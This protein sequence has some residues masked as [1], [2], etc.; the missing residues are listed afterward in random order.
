MK[1]IFLSL[2]MLGSVS[3]VTKEVV[4]VFQPVSYHDTDSASE[5]GVKGQL[6]QAAVVDR[7]VVLSGAFPED[8][9][10][11]VA[12]PH[13]LPTN[14]PTYEVEEVNLLLICGLALEVTRSENSIEV[15]LD[16]AGLKVPETVELTPRQII[17]MTIEAIRRTLR[18]YYQEGAHDTFECHLTLSGLAEEHAKLAELKADFQVGPGAQRREAE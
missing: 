18:V 1:V 17:S 7:P 2:L 14:N 15:V 3:G 12:M 11:S 9:V 8:L 13:R 6:V 4:R 5:Y 16:C 10:K